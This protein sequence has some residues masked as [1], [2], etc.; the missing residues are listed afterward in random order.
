MLTFPEQARVNQKISVAELKRQGLENKIASSVKSVEWLYKLSPATMN[1]AATDAVKEIE[2][3]RLILKPDADV[4]R[5]RAAVIS[6][7]DAKIPSPL[8]FLLEDESGECLGVALNLK[9]SGGTVSGESQLFRLF[10]T[11][12]PLSLPVGVT[13][14]ESFFLHLAA[15]VGGMALRPGETLRALNE[16]HY[17]LQSLRDAEA[18]LAK[19]IRNEKQLHIRFAL[20]K[21]RKAL[22]QEIAQCQSSTL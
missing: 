4:W 6:A 16:R 21:E 14:L 12:K 19:R 5:T 13:T 1:L 8:I 9:P 7:L 3:M 22:E 15:T 10:H 17:R 2:V 11:E 18:R 20:A